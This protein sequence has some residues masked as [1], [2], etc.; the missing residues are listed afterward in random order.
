MTTPPTVPWLSAR[1]WVAVVLLAVATALMVVLLVS[2]GNARTY[3]G[4]ET[5]PA[6]VR[7]HVGASLDT[8]LRHHGV[9]AGR[10]RTWNVRG[11]SGRVLRIEQRA[12]VPPSFESL[13]CNLEL[14]QRV[15]EVGA[16]VVGTERSRE[17]SVTLHIEGGGDVFRSITFVVDPHL[18]TQGSGKE[19]RH[20]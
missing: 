11:P 3:G 7:E 19:E 1:A 16:R 12:A 14:S 15:A 18:A 6:N 2:G 17:Q 9:E 13:A 5:I 8:V 20:R 10:I 4:L